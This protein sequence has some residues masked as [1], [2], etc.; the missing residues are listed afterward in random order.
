MC[1]VERKQ[2]VLQLEVLEKKPP[3]DRNRQEAQHL[4]LKTVKTL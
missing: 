2:R 4:S 3:N 1:T